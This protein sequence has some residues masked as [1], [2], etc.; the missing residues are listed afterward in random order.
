MAGGHPWRGSADD[1]SAPLAFSSSHADKPGSRRQ[2]LFAAPTL[3]IGS[4]GYAAA[5]SKQN[6][7]FLLSSRLGDAQSK[8]ML[9]NVSAQCS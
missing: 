9:K 2:R 5:K 3:L 1:F 6:A 4:L 8:G 7:A